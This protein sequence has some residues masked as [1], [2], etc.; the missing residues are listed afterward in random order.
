MVNS[1][2]N[3][4]HYIQS[5]TELVLPMDDLALAYMVTAGHY[6]NLDSPCSNK[7]QAVHTLRIQMPNVEIIKSTHTAI[8][9]HPD[10][11]LQ[12]RQ[13]HFL[14]GLTKSLLSIGTLCD[15]G[16]QATFND[17]SVHIKNKQSGNIIMKGKRD[18]RTNL[19]MLNLT[20]QKKPMMESTTPDKYFSG[21]AY[22]CKSKSTLADYNHASFWSTTHSGWWKAIKKTSS[23]LGQA[24]HW[25]WCTNT[26]QKKQST[27]IGHLQQPRKGLRS[28]QEQLMH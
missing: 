15:H 19:Y 27:I 7:Q 6:L 17:K 26:S 14:P 2:E 25:T 18:T 16:C 22:E 21:G 8:L 11:P 20:Q 9:S 13:T 12:E 3:Y 24:Y 5:N 1:N 28:T 10:L 4:I 23:L